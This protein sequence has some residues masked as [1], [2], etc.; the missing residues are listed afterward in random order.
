MCQWRTFVKL[1]K[2]APKSDVIVLFTSFILTVLF[3][4][5]VA[6]EIGMVLACLLFIKR[7]SEETH[8]NSWTYVDDDTPDVDERLQKLPLQIRVYESQASVLRSQQVRLNTLS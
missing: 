8:V 4:L 7:M 5:V 3:D 1:V 2:T 6:I